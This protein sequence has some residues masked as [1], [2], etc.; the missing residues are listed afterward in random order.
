MSTTDIF[1][2]LRLRVRPGNSWV[3]RHLRQWESRYVSRQWP[4]I[5]G[6][7]PRSGTTL[8]RVILDTHPNLACGPES[9][10]L[11][12]CFLREELME[13]F[14]IPAAELDQLS[15]A[16]TDHAHLTELFFTRYA[17]RRGKARWAE[18]TPA[19]V[20]HLAYVFRHFPNAKFVH[21]VRDGRD[22]VCS[23][24][25]YPKY[26]LVDGTLVATQIQRSPQACIQRW[27]RDTAAGMA[28]RGHPNYLELKYEDL[29]DHT[30]QTL[31]RLCA[32]IGEMWRPE[33]LEYYQHQSQRPDPHN[34]SGCANVLQP[35]SS[36]AVGRWR[37]E[38]TG[39]ELQSVHQL[40]AG[41]LAELGYGVEP[42]AG[43]DP[44]PELVP[45]AE[46]RQY[47]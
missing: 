45:C 21:V 8:T 19:N 22:V 29:V 44:Q 20:R 34:F 46:V 3:A 26:R 17:D 1:R 14:E 40:A 33:L 23:L 37:T 24:R 32:F 27:L 16:A 28:W 5:I 35:I 36:Q 30:G 11:A 13:R 4:I 39:P 41:R 47:R 25:T 12:G 10:L 38:L 7:C 2:S 31:R 18:K 6:G 42:P 15:I 9:S 43:Q